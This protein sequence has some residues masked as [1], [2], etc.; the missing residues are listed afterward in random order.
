MSSKNTFPDNF[1]HIGNLDRRDFL[2]AVS[3]SAAGIGMSKIQAVSA[4]SPK[5]NIGQSKLFQLAKPL[6]VKPVLVYH[7]YEKLKDTTWREW[8]GLKSEQDVDREV[9]RINAE[10]AKLA[11]KAE[12]KLDILGVDRVNSDENL[13][14][15]L[16]ADCDMYLVYGA[17]AGGPG[18]YSFKWI[19]AFVNSGKP[20]VM[21][22][23]HKSGPVSLL[24]ETVHP[25]FLRRGK[26]E[27][28]EKNLTVDDIVVDDYDQVLWRL[29]AWR[30]LL[31][32]KGARIVV[33]GEAAS[34][35]L[36][37]ECPASAR[38]IWNL[39]IVVI[40]NMKFK[41][42]ITKAH[43]D[44]KVVK[45]AQQQMDEYLKNGVVSIE[46][47]KEYILNAFILRNAMKDV[48]LE[49]NSNAVTVGGCMSYGDI[50]KTTPCMALSMIND[51]G[52]MAFCE[53]DFSVIPA[54]ML[55][56]NIS[57]KPVFLNDPTFPHDGICT[58]AHC[59]STRRLDGVNLE[60][61]K[62]LTHCESD[63]G[64]AP[65][66]LYSKGQRITNLIPSFDGKKWLGFTGKI[67]DHPAYDI[68]RSQFDCTIEGD[69]QK[70]LREMRGFHWITNY[71]Q[72]L[73]EVG[74][75]LGK[76]GIEW[77]NVSA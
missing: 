36:P 9:N 53:A 3:L 59:N 28:I 25:Y 61:V 63:Y 47:E 26:D 46:T 58:C 48:M 64:A 41:E 50:A 33:I 14:K 13:A 7:M 2:K 38:D 31:N 67:T 51:E 70:L 5:A 69:W 65:K 17:G 29:R 34:G 76:V 73:N 62:I 74:Y 68:C 35:G 32:T 45:L 72:Y 15:A 77:T 12:F 22:L 40:D 60:P 44:S 4:E 57:G 24:Y 10:L 43:A 66:V 75:V 11:D 21:F 52:F 16:Q 1:Q 55:L 37:H 54:G 27:F 20:N 39:D 42:R 19:E 30:G 56:S 8:G 71:G 49:N 6:K 23:R 18:L